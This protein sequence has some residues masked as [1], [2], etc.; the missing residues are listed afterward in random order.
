MLTQEHHQAS[1][2][3]N[4]LLQ[5]RP[6]VD[7]K[8]VRVRGRHE[9]IRLDA[10][11][12]ERLIEPADRETVTVGEE[13]RND[14]VRVAV[15]PRLDRHQERLEGAGVLEQAGRVAQLQVAVLMLV[16][17]SLQEADAEVELR[18]DVEV[19][20]LLGQRSN[21]WRVVSS[22]Q[23]DA[24]VLAAAVLGA[25]VACRLRSHGREKQEESNEEP[26][27]GHS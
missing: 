26:V 21:E 23:R 18:G 3:V 16:R 7:S 13:Q 11:A 9:S 5:C 22:D 14:L 17:L 8:D 20:V 2:T 19:L 6:S 24:R 27:E 10:A 1:S 4:E 15:H 25:A 12:R